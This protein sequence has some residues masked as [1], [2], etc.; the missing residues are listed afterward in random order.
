MS[1]S[2]DELSFWYSFCKF[3]GIVIKPLKFILS[4]FIFLETFNVDKKSRN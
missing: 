2:T 3:F 4:A 1:I